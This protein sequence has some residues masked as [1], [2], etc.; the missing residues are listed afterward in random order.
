MKYMKDGFN[1]SEEQRRNRAATR[2]KKLL[3]YLIAKRRGNQFL[4]AWSEHLKMTPLGDVLVSPL[5]PTE[6]ITLDSLCAA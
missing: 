4:V 3:N 1:L 2:S 5:D 6:G